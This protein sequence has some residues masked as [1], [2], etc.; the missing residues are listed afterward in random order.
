VAD[1]LPPLIGHS[2]RALRKPFSNI[3]ARTAAAQA[4]SLAGKNVQMITGTGGGVDLW[5]RVVARHIRKH[6]PGML[7]DRM[8]MLQ[9]AF[10][11]TMKDPDFLADAKKQKLDVAPADGE[12]LTALVKNIYATPKP[13]VDKVGELIK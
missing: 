11:V 3:C 8:K 7:A 5:G 10:M 9:D 12:H 13:I 6:L 2:T 1:E 4:P